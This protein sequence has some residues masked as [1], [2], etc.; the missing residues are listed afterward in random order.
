MFPFF[1]CC[2][3]KSTKEKENE[4]ARLALNSKYSALSL[5]VTDTENDQK[6][7]SAKFELENRELKDKIESLQSDIENLQLLLTKQH[8]KFLLK[9]ELVRLQE[10]D[11]HLDTSYHDL[12][13][14][15]ESLRNDFHEYVHGSHILNSQTLDDL[16]KKIDDFDQ[17]FLQGHKVSP[18][19]SYQKTESSHGPSVRR[20]SLDSLDSVISNQE[21]D[22]DAQAQTY[23][24]SLSDGDGSA[25]R[26][27]EHDEGDGVGVGVEDP[28]APALAPAPAPATIAD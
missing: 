12:K 11:N 17:K 4:D 10:K 24:F 25:D 6:E 15:L 2:G 14:S 7:L 28:A 9:A 19:D 13:R 16:Y 3:K 22:T 26:G 23:I 27:E 1:D 5:R 8:Q 20:Q 18:R 21:E